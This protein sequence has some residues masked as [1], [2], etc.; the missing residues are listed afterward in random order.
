MTG[1]LS[2]YKL[3]KMM[4]LFFQGY[5]QMYIANKLKIDQSTVSLHVS[6][7][8]SLTEQEGLQATAEEYGVM[9]EVEALHGLAVELKKAK[10]TVEETKAGLKMVRLF[11]KFGIKEEDYGDLIQACTKMKDEGYID[12]AVKLNK[13]ENATGMTHGELLDHYASTHKELKK[14]QQERE[15]TTAKLSAEKEE[16]ADID[17]QK[18]AASQGL[19]TYMDQLGV[20][21]NR[22]KLV[23]GLAKALK[24]AGIS[25]KELGEYIAWQQVLNKAGIGLDT[26]TAIVE[27]AKV[28][29]SHD[30]GKGLLKSL[31]DYGGINEAIQ[32]SQ[33]KVALLEKQAAGLEQLAQQKGKLMTEIAE[34]EAEKV[35]LQSSL[36]EFQARKHEL[37]GIKSQIDSLTTEKA[38]LEKV[39]SER[40]AHNVALA[41]EIKA[42]QQKVS[43]L[44]QLEAKWDDLAARIFETEARLSHE[45]YRLQVLDSFLAFV[46][47]SSLVEFEKFVAAPPS[48]LALVKDG[49]TSKEALIAVLVKDIA[50]DS[51]QSWRCLSCGARFSIDKPAPFG[52]RCP[53][54]NMPTQ[55]VL[56]QDMI[57]VLKKAL[58]EVQRP[59]LEVKMVK[60]PKEPS[61]GSASKGEVDHGP[62]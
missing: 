53:R 62:Q 18:K 51:L 6:K 29:T 19:K 7:F 26:F 9:D 14:E 61:P 50:G 16:L 1:K 8:K 54:C 4:S 44:S 57:T 35:S 59:V 46:N 45:R 28:L 40:E 36:A 11:Q 31:S 22:L 21:M 10:L 41:G 34:L 43:D 58:A 20:D 49:K 27:K 15:T 17:K 38:E 23:E 32:D 24:D 13:L 37:D 52:Y 60:P 48:L 5:T 39:M 33:T 47:S 12:D 2:P 3:S 30:Q 56:D 25:N 55:V 42:K